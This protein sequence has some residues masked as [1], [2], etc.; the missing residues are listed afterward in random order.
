VWIT[1]GQL[2]ADPAAESTKASRHLS[3]PPPRSISNS[4]ATFL[5]GA[6][7]QIVS[8]WDHASLFGRGRRRAAEPPRYSSLSSFRACAL[9][10]GNDQM[11]SAISEKSAM[12]SLQGA[13]PARFVTTAGEGLAL[14]FSAWNSSCAVEMTPHSLAASAIVPAAANAPPRLESK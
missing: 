9:G 6:L 14:C 11:S 3:A 2:A 1:W 10:R 4:S 5:G 8:G 12:N 7:L 13:S